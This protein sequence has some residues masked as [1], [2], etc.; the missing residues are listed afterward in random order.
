MTALSFSISYSNLLTYSGSGDSF[1]CELG[2]NFLCM[3][4]YL[5][6]S[7]RLRSGVG[8]DTFYDNLFLISGEESE[9]TSVYKLDCSSSG[10]IWCSGICDYSDA[11][12][13]SGA[14]A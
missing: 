2:G 14:K 8:R 13:K 11:L 12:M 7:T 5:L 6:S 3:F 10:F 4:F 9:K 1:F